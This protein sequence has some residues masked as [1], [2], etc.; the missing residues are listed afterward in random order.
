MLLFLEKTS[1]FIPLV[2]TVWRIQ[3]IEKELEPLC[4]K[5]LQYL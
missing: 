3:K 4:E 1:K 5:Q 2:M